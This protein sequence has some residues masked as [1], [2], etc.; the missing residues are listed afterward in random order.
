MRRRVLLASVATLAASHARGQTAPSA[1][2][3]GLLSIGAVPQQPVVW[4]P[5][6]ERMRALGYEEGRT[7]A[8]HRGF[9]AGREDRIEDLARE[10]V[11]A[12]PALLVVTGARESVIVRRLDAPMPC[13]MMVNPDPIGLGLVTSLARPGGRMTGL[14]TMDSELYGKR[15]ELLREMVP[16]L[17]RVRALT[18]GVSPLYRPDTAWA[19]QLA[20]AAG[21]LGIGL[22]MVQAD[23]PDAIDR[24]IAEAATLGIGG[25]V[26]PF[27]GLFVARR[28]DV[29]AS[30]L[31]HR[32]PAIYGGAEFVADGGLMSYSA[33]ISDLSRR[34]ADFVDRIL[35]GADPAALP[36]ERPTTFQLAINLAAARGIG[37]SVPASLLDRADEVIE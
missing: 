2:R 11:A 17:A 25:L 16:R 29:A 34:A 21:T 3:I 26:V 12:R 10:V 7:V 14:T 8:Y 5:F 30:A 28:Q 33:K 15:L 9:A 23:T 32:L 31:R 19:R 27:D 22:D 20:A 35:R 18:S 24:V 36:I 6:F 1:P 37:L 4:L 13:I